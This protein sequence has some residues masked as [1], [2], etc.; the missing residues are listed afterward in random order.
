MDFD[1]PTYFECAA[2]GTEL[3]ADSVQYDD[4]GYPQC[5]ECAARTGPLASVEA[6]EA[7]EP[8]LA[9]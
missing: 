2:C 3:P 7:V 6:A 1:W 9:D 5:P 4:L 8:E